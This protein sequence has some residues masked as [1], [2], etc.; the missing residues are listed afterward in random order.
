MCFE[1]S[2]YK[3]EWKHCKKISRYSQVITRVN[4]WNKMFTKFVYKVTPKN[5]VA[6]HWHLPMTTTQWHEIPT[7]SDTLLRFD[8]RSDLIFSDDHIKRKCMQV[9]HH[10][11]ALGKPLISI[12]VLTVNLCKVQKPK[13][14]FAY[15]IQMNGMLVHFK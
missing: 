3:Q 4:I 11:T 7:Q 5:I 15:T 2:T 13:R 6:R 8:Q 10:S 1:M 12:Q 9:Q 14:K